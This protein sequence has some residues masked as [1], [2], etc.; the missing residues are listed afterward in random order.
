VKNVIRFRQNP[1]SLRRKLLIDRQ[2]KRRRLVPRCRTHSKL[3]TPITFVVSSVVLA[4]R[5]GVFGAT[6]PEFRPLGEQTATQE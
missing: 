3:F 5:H 4:E 2:E 6:M 1:I